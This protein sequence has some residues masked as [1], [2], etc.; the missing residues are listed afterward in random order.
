M[1]EHALGIRWVVACTAACWAAW[2]CG[3][4]LAAD[5]VQREFVQFS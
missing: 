2:L 5:A 3:R 1:E 4:P